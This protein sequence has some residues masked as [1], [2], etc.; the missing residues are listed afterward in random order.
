M[1]QLVLLGWIITGSA[2]CASL[3]VLLARESGKVWPVSLLMG[4]GAAIAALGSVTAL[5]AA[6]S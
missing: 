6:F 1:L 5:F 4:G 2:L 3:S